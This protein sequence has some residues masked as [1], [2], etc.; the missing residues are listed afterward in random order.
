MP[1]PSERNSIRGPYDA[2]RRIEDQDVHIREL[3]ELRLRL[4]EQFANHIA[5]IQEGNWPAVAEYDLPECI[6]FETTTYPVDMT[7]QGEFVSRHPNQ[8]AHLPSR[9]EVPGV[10]KLTLGDL[11]AAA[12]WDMLPTL[13]P[14][15]RK[16]PQ[17]NHARQL[18]ED[19]KYRAIM[20]RVF[21]ARLLLA[22]RIWKRATQLADTGSAWPDIPVQ[23]EAEHSQNTAQLIRPQVEEALVKPGMLAERITFT[24]A[25][26][27]GSRV[28]PPFRPFRARAG[29][30][31]NEHV[32]LLM[33]VE[34]PKAEPTL[35]GID[36][37]T[38]T[39]PE[40][41]W[42]KHFVQ[43]DSGRS[44]TTGT[45]RDPATLDYHLRA[46]RSVLATPIGIQWLRVLHQWSDRRAHTTIT[47]EYMLRSDHRVEL[48][49]RMLGY[50]RTPDGQDYYSS[51]M[52]E[53]TYRSVYGQWDT[54]YP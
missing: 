30:D 47:P 51:T 13:N 49:E 52:I 18:I 29:V 14:D 26:R 32:D 22:E 37:T 9:Q 31:M 24:M 16:R 50:M 2:I 19:V 8:F 28:A 36:V 5:A 43:R 23:Y 7:R 41:V 21:V 42:R 15:S 53:K 40:D 38:K 6:P 11:D 44:A 1:E 17:S 4:Q 33:R 12:E 27:L 46:A 54:R 48:G 45:L 25:A 20:R 3:R 39:A 10:V 35:V 34:P